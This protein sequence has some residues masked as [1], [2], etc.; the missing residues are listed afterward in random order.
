MSLQ[1]EFHRAFGLKPSDLEPLPSHNAMRKMLDQQK[2]HAGANQ[3]NGLSGS[4]FE[5]AAIIFSRQ[6]NDPLTIVECRRRNGVNEK[7][8]LDSFVHDGLP[9]EGLIKLISTPSKVVDSWKS[10][11]QDGSWPEARQ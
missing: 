5:N 11:T 3:S 2:N 6:T 7:F 4:E 10:G 9:Q 8:A 1:T